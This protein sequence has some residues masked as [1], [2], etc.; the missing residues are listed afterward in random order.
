MIRG[1]IEKHYWGLIQYNQT[2]EKIRKQKFFKKITKLKK[3]TKQNIFKNEN[4]K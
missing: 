2:K 4:K 3:I 1:E